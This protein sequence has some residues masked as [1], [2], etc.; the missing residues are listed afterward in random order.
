[1]NIERKLK[2]ITEKLSEKIILIESGDDSEQQLR[3]AQEELKQFR[4]R[5]QAK[6]EGQRPDDIENITRMERN[7]ARLQRRV[8][9]EKLGGN[10]DVLNPSNLDNEFEDNLDDEYSNDDVSQ[11]EHDLRQFKSN[12]DT[13][14]PEDQKTLKALE[15]LVQ[16]EHDLRQ[17]KSNMDTND[18]EDQKT[19]KAL[20]KQVNDMQSGTAGDDISSPATTHDTSSEP[21]VKGDPEVFRLQQD[22]IA[23]GANI[24]ADGI[25]GPRTRAAQQQFGS[26]STGTST[27]PAVK[28][29]PEVFK[30]QQ[31]LIAKGANIKADGIM[32]P[33]T[34]AAQQQFGS[35][36]AQQQAQP[37]QQQAQPRQQVHTTRPRPGSTAVDR[38]LGNFSLNESV[39]RQT[40]DD[41][42]ARIKYLSRY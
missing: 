20:E 18:P 4:S 32:G 11:A 33:R 8:N 23:K 24:K 26:S 41:A 14:N 17:F 38:A 2:R 27:K 25:M 1:M 40:T 5:L 16:A 9:D 13:N 21:A 37:R 35:S 15:D 42:L 36:S 7:I 19:L 3:Q 12:M 30:L 34:R 28:G 39:E 6:G 10:I 31:D 29:D 22:L